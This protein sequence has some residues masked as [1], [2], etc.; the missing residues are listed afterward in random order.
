LNVAGSLPQVAFP[1]RPD[2]QM[3]TRYQR[4][5]P[6]R[7]PVCLKLHRKIGGKRIKSLNLA[8]GAASW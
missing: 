2:Y 5:L 8:G 1:T 4:E 7:D 6:L 3:F